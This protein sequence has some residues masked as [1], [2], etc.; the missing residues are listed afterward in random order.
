MK[1]KGQSKWNHSSGVTSVIIFSSG[2]IMRAFTNLQVYNKWFSLF[3]FK[4]A[5][6]KNIPILYEILILLAY[7]FI[8]MT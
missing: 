7:S 1:T 8:I 4:K 2:I 3:F 6:N 5:L